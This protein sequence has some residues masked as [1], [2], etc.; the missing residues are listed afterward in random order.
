M[1][2]TADH[3]ESLGE[4]GCWGHGLNLYQE[5]LLVP[6]LLRGRGV[7]AGAVDEPIQLLDLAPTVLGAAGVPVAPTMMGR[8]LLEGGSNHPIVSSTFGAGPM[9]WSW[10][11]ADD[12]VLLRMAEQPGLGE[13]ARS[14]MIGGGPREP[15]AFAFDLASD[16][17]EEQPHALPDRLVDPVVA[18]FNG[19][20]GRMVPGLQIGLSQRVGG[21]STRLTIDS[22]VAVVQAWS[23]KPMVVVRTGDELR[24]SCED[25]FPACILAA[26]LASTSAEISTASR[27]LF[28]GEHR[29]RRVHSPRG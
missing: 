6:L 2:L 4:R 9:R 13:V 20:A 10:R 8:S 17:A 7:A 21:I 19:T 11:R 14:K 25:A 16:P 18:A 27:Q 24:L 12:K 29:R 23:S 28:P 26:T 5:A 1:V 15:G 22:E 3:G